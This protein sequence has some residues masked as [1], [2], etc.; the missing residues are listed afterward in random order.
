[1]T[2]QQ[3]TLLLSVPETATGGK[4]SHCFFASLWFLRRPIIGLRR[5]CCSSSLVVELHHRQVKREPLSQR[6][7]SETDNASEQTNAGWMDK[8]PA[9]HQ[10]ADSMQVTFQF[11]VLCRPPSAAVAVKLQPHFDL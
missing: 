11:S 1:M 10:T 8:P 5:G 3:A 6:G 4:Q 9:G 7:D 2:K